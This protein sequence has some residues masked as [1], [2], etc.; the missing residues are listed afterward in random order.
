MPP[1]VAPGDPRQPADSSVVRRLPD[2]GRHIVVT[3]AMGV[4]KTTVGRLLARRLGLPFVDSDE[5][6]ETREGATGAA[7]AAAEGVERLHELELEVF[8]DL[9]W[10]RP[11]SVIAPA[12]SVVDHR[13]GR[14]AMTENLTVWLKAPDHVIAV[15]QGAGGHRRPIDRTGRAELRAKR[16]P[17]LEAVS[18]MEVDTGS[19][20]PREVV[21]ALVDQLRGLSA[22]QV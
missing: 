21:D 16:A 17:H 2:D 11:R 13:L 7:I 22:R 1:D 5:T 6:L 20:T 15:R 4:G 12:S 8:L 9:C 19:A 10:R 3:G 14:T 18:A